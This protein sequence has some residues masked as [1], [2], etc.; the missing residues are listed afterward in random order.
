MLFA[1]EVGFVEKNTSGL[2][3]AAFDEGDSRWSQD[4][5]G[6][7]SAQTFEPKPGLLRP[8]MPSDLALCPMGS[9][10]VSVVTDGRLALWSGHEGDPGDAGLDGPDG[11][12]GLSGPV[13]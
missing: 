8:A 10:E 3:V 4:R 11:P 12:D 5:T 9:P 7:P 13:L 6:R 2:P 1:T